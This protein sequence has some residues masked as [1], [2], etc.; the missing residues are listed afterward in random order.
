MTDTPDDFISLAETCKRLRRSRWT[1]HRL[2]KNGTLQAK[3]RGDAR[4]AEV[5]VDPTSVD[6]YLAGRPVQ[7][8]KEKSP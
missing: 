3:K 5:L 2:I 7:P 8:D 6:A 4:N 1:V